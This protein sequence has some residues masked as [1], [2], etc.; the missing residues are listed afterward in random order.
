MRRTINLPQTTLEYD[1]AFLTA[2]EADALFAYLRGTVAWKQE[3][4]RGRPFPRR[5]GWYADVGIDYRY[6]GIEHRGDGW[7]ERLLTLKHS[8]EE[9]AGS[10]FN[11]VLLNLY[12]NGR[13]S[14]GY[15]SDNEPE[16]GP[17]PIVASLSLG[18]ERNFALKH[19]ETGERINLLLTHGS[20]LMMGPGCQ[21]HYRHMVPKTAK[22]VSERINLTFRRVY[23]S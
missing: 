23:P 18:A 21:I 3:I 14:M 6:S 12:R 2:A 10:T 5:V 17:D 11:S 7:P 9:A 19:V 16:L 1:E 8:I 15:H 22:P 13:D 20:L 4:G